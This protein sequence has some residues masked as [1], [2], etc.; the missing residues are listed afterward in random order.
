MVLTNGDRVALERVAAAPS[1]TQA[2][3]FRARIVL[4]SERSSVAEAARDLDISRH[5]VVKWCTRYAELGVE[6]LGDRPR[7]GR[8]VV[9]DD[10]IRAAVLATQLRHPAA[11]VWT[12]REVAADLGISQTAVSRVRRATFDERPGI[13]TRSV[14]GTSNR[15]TLA[16]AFSSTATRVLL[17]HETL[18]PAPRHSGARERGGRTMREC[19]RTVLSTQLGCEPTGAGGDSAASEPELLDVLGRVNKMVPPGRRVITIVDSVLPAESRRWLTKHPRFSIY[20]V[21]PSSWFAQ[22]DAVVESLDRNETEQ[23]LGLERDVRAWRSAESRGSFRWIRSA[24]FDE[25]NVDTDSGAPALPAVARTSAPRLVTAVVKELRES[26]ATGTFGA[27][28]KIPEEPLAARL[29]VSRGPI[30]DAL[31]ILAEDGLV[32]LE[33]HRGAYI[34]IPTRQDIFDTYTARG[35]LG[36]LLLRRLATKGRVR[37]VPVEAALSDVVRIARTGDAP[38]TGDADIRWQDAAAHAADM[39]RIEK[40]FSRLSLQL[41]MFISILGLDYAY[42]VDEIVSDDTEILAALRAQDPDL[43]TTLWSRKIDKSVFNMVELFRQHEGAQ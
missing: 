33:P 27:G 31:Q 1:S 17:F 3:A 28:Q 25:P 6:G 15:M 19:I 23:M 7:P 12:T 9:I 42:A 24:R 18:V 34:P 37:L 16:A 22:L 13:I 35:P 40:I 21:E 30:R 36:A 41:R 32:A 20:E 29:G 14:L 5:T 26:I 11:G 38:A 43:V 10:A 2:L 8:P 39:P 4:I